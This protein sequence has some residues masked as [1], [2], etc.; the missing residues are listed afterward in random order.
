M[1]KRKKPTVFRAL[2]SRG[3]KKPI[4]GRRKA[5]PVISDSGVPRITNDTVSKHR[6]EVLSGARK[7]I[8]PLQHSRHKIVLIS[9]VLL[10]V[11]GLSFMTYTLL[12]LYKFQNTSNFTYQLTRIMPLPV[13][14]VDGSFVSY[15]AYLFEL[16]HYI[17]YFE[18]QQEVDFST[19]QGKAQ[20]AEQKKRSME[21]VI[22]QAYVQ[23]IAQQKGLSVSRD[24]ID[25]QLDLLRAQNRLGVD[26]KVFEDVLRDYWGWTVSDFRR[27][28]EQEL[29]AAKVIASLDTETKARADAALAELKSGVDFAAVAKK[30]SDDVSTK[31]KGG[32][33]GVAISQTDRNIPPQT[34]SAIFALQPGQYSG[35]TNIGYGLEIVKLMSKEDDKAKAARIYFAYKELNTFLNDLKSQ[36]PA[37]AYIKT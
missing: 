13:A 31:E 30:Y 17:H 7:Y 8:Y 23:K 9:V 18:N 20:L 11:V 36:K 22:N 28:I 26:N 37:T 29:L 15:E 4:L 27:S 25:A 14:R 34:V 5:V 32:D 16:R 10:V 3:Y 19:D 21:K 6:E 1:I 33:F 2:R 12:S 35:I 24:E